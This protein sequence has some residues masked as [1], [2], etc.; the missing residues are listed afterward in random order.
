MKRDFK[1]ELKTAFDADHAALSASGKHLSNSALVRQHRER[2]ASAYR[3]QVEA[4]MRALD[5]KGASDKKKEAYLN[6]ARRMFRSFL[7]SN[8][9]K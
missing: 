4:H 1:H 9:F 8:E 3:E 6:A 7:G 2:F 5:A